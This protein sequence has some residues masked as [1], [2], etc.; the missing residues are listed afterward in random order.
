MPS[1]KQKGQANK[2]S[3]I[4]EVYSVPKEFVFIERFFVS[5]EKR[6]KIS[7]KDVI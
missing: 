2:I 4:K 6:H 1:R 3:T 5:G 7:Y